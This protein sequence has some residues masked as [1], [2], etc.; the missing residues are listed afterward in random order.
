MRRII[1][2]LITAVL[3]FFSSC[4]F[5]MKTKVTVALYDD[6]TWEQVTGKSMWFKVRYFDGESVKTEYLSE[7][8]RSLTLE[9][10]G[11]TLAVFAFYPLGELSPLGGFWEG[12]DGR[13]V[14]VQSPWGYFAAML[15]DAAETMPE[16]VRELSVRALK[17]DNPDLGAIN[18]GDFLSS[19][20]SGTLS[21]SSITLSKKY[22]V[23]LDGVLNGYWESLFAHT[24]SF[25][26]KR[27]GDGMTLSLL[28]GIWYYLNPERKMML[29]IVISDK[30]EYWVKHKAMP[31]WS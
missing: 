12:G 30:G 24:S 22:S 7:G 14:Y 15:I 17:F 9:V 31:K 19:L 23:P 5:E 3:L 29:E 28:P 8:E 16:S 26:I 27:T 13:K 18:R 4:S 11:A 21:S 25:S 10:R 2:V 20:Y 1:A 6:L